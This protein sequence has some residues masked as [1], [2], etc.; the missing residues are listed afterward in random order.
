MTIVTGVD[1]RISATRNSMQKLVIGT[2]GLHSLEH[3]L[4][5]CVRVCVFVHMCVCLCVF[6]CVLSHLKVA[7]AKH[8]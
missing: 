1:N 5:V 3:S 2:L 4:C 8:A 7:L 6:V